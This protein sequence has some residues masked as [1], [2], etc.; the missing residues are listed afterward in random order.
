MPTIVRRVDVAAVRGDGEPVDARRGVVGDVGYLLDEGARGI[1]AHGHAGTA[2]V[3]GH[4]EDRVRGGPLDDEGDPERAGRRVRDVG[5]AESERL[6]RV[7]R[8]TL[9]DPI[10]GYIKILKLMLF[11]AKWWS[12]CDN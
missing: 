10:S 3:V 7:D 11:P 4:A 12:A 1:N 6:V 5:P 8:I 2:R 9:V